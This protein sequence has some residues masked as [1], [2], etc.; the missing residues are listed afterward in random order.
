MNK[1]A[2][3]VTGIVVGAFIIFMGI[4]VM[5]GSL[6]GAVRLS[7]AVPPSYDS[8]Y[9]MF[10]ADFYNYVSNNA[11]QA[12]KASSKI[13]YNLYEIAGLLKNTLGLLLMA[14]GAFM[15]CFFGCKLP[16]KLQTEAEPSDVIAADSL[17]PE[18]TEAESESEAE[19]DQPS[20]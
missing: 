11:A 3:S 20:V 8:G 6:G 7:E 13:A 18:E 19:S 16:D 10:G 17:T 15:I 9:A 14:F 12:A 4:L 1:K 5:A 2:F